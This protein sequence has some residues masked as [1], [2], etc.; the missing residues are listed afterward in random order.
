MVTRPHTHTHTHIHTQ[1]PFIQC[2]CMWSTHLL[3]FRA[4]RSKNTSSAFAMLVASVHPSVGFRGFFCFFFIS[5]T[6]AKASSCCVINS[7]T[8]T[9]TETPQKDVL[10]LT[11]RLPLIW[12][13]T[14]ARWRLSPTQHII[15]TEQHGRQAE[16]KQAECRQRFP[17]FISGF[18]SNVRGFIVRLLKVWRNTEL[19]IYIK[20]LRR[21]NNHFA[22][23]IHDFKESV[24]TTNAHKNSEKK[25]LW[26]QKLIHNSQLATFSFFGVH[27]IQQISKNNPCTVSCSADP[28]KHSKVI[29]KTLLFILNPEAFTDQPLKQ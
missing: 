8:E 13:E 3:N 23:L 16:S 10:T 17:H 29:Q 25:V 6:E 19:L 15:N 7:L 26:L 14:A 28:P 20:S 24:N 11:L 2:V 27:Y 1:C 5:G 12:N 4:V 9:D 18:T 21:E 22:S